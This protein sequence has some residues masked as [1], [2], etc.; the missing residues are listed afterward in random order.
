MVLSLFFVSMMGAT[1]RPQS[2]DTK[3]DA[4]KRQFNR[5]HVSA[6]EMEVAMKQAGDEINKRFERF[7]SLL[8]E[9][10]STLKNIES[11]NAQLGRLNNRLKAIL[12][13][14]P[15]DSVA[16]YELEYVDPEGVKPDTSKKKIDYPEVTVPERRRSFFDRLFKRN[17]Q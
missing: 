8:D 7:D 16:K 12:L 14:F 9:R 10:E 5:K 4:T 17:R 15:K 1:T 11:Q 3:Q 2:P 13:R 6:S